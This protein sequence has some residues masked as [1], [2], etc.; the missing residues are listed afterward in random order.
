MT[1]CT[2]PHSNINAWQKSQE[3]PKNVLRILICVKAFAHETLKGCAVGE[4]VH[5]LLHP[6]RP[7][8]KTNTLDPST[9]SIKRSSVP[10][11]T[12]KPQASYKPQA[13]DSLHKP[14][15]LYDENA[16]ALYARPQVPKTCHQTPLLG[17]LCTLN[18]KPETV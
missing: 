4:P 9:R 11:N 17:A 2:L 14:V 1:S 16:K 10:F 6:A 7:K 5:L 18:P 13:N 15:K 8:T 12:P 3:D